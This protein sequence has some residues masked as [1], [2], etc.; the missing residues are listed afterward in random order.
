MHGKRNSGEGTKFSYEF[1]NHFVSSKIMKLLKYKFCAAKEAKY[2]CFTKQELM[3][4]NRSQTIS[5]VFEL[6]VVY[7]GMVVGLVRLLWSF[8]LLSHWLEEVFK[9]AGDLSL[10]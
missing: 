6:R 4:G 7:M 2:S 1:L 9:L 10:T 5:R 8:L 3:T